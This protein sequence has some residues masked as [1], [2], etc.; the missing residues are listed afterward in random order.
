MLY[1]QLEPR[2]IL[3]ATL[4][5]V[6]L[7]QV[8]VQVGTFNKIETDSNCNYNSTSISYELNTQLNPINLLK[9]LHVLIPTH[10]LTEFQLPRIYNPTV[11]HPLARGLVHVLRWIIQF[12]ELM[13]EE[14]RDF[15]ELFFD[16]VVDYLEEDT[17]SLDHV[18]ELIEDYMMQSIDEGVISVETSDKMM[19]IIL[20]Y[21]GE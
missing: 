12:E 13:G 16:F 15:D 21:T 10:F 1:N 4:L 14:F 9:C 17:L 8:R 7:Q 11:I 3:E 5:K 20:S 18:F 19:S 2:A 6:R